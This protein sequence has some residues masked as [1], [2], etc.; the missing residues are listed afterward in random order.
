MSCSDRGRPGFAL[1]A[2]LV[3]TGVVTLIFLVAMTALDSLNREAA[4]ARQRLDAQARSFTAE[5]RFIYI[6]ATEPLGAQAFRIGASRITNEFDA[7][8]PDDAAAG[9]TPL[10]IDGRGYALADMGVRVS[11][12]DAAGLINV[13]RL[14][15]AEFERLLVQAGASESDAGRLWPAYGDYVD[16]DDLRQVNGAEEGD[17]GPGLPPNRPLR[18]ADELLSVRGV[19]EAVSDAR[20]R[21]LRLI[22]IADS[23]Q[24]TMNV[25]TAPREM[26]KVVFGLNDAEADRAIAFREGQPI[27]SLYALRQITGAA[28]VA[29]DEMIYT[30]PSGRFVVTIADQ[31]SNWTYRSRVVITPA[32]PQRP[33]WID[34][35]EVTRP[36]RGGENDDDVAEL[37]S[38]AD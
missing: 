33:F 21:R 31:A 20:W 1:P 2:V 37:P 38:P 13:P 35:R 4:G 16:P 22:T 3:V 25:N 29:D 8:A 24:A 7:P 32:D 15:R 36:N 18:T 19:R 26:L 6:A 12:Q 34:E 30:F 10:W 11:V 27:T 9:E 14:G 5:A 23:T 17:Y 28:V